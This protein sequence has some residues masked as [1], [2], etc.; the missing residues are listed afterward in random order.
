MSSE[1]KMRKLYDKNLLAILSEAQLLFF[2]GRVLRR[3]KRS[4]EFRF[5]G[6]FFRKDGKKERER[7]NS[8]S[9]TLFYKRERDHTS[10][11]HI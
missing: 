4:K 6:V 8:N 10:L 1:K 3:G 11:M 2:G 9:K 7:E 5:K